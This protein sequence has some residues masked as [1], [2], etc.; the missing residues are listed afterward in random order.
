MHIDLSVHRH[1]YVYTSVVSCKMRT[2][3][4]VQHHSI[5]IHTHSELSWRIS[6]EMDLHM[7]AKD[8]ACCLSRRQMQA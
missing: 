4:V 8:L 6:G 1:M 3:A 5:C 7:M 2:H